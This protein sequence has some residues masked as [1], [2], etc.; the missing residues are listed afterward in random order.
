MNPAIIAVAYN[1]PDSLRRLLTSLDKAVYENDV[2]LVISIDKADNETEVL[3]VAEKFEWKYGK[4][5]IRLFPE[6]QGLRKHIIQ[7]GDLSNEYDAVI[8]L[9]DD[10][11]V[12]KGFYTYMCSALNFYVNEHQITGISLYSHEWNGYAGKFFQPIVD[13]FDTYLG[14]FSITWGQ[15]WTSKWWNN[16]KKWYLEHEDKLGFNRLIPE[17]INHWSCQSWG[18]YFVNYI[19]EKNLYYVIPRTSLSTNFSEVGQHCQNGNTDH[20][21]K[22]LFSNK[23][24]YNF[25]PCE[26]AQ[27]YD[28]F[29]ENM[30]I[31]KYLDKEIADEGIIVDLAGIGRYGEHKRYLLTTSIL[32]YKIV[33]SFGLQMRPIDSNVIYGINGNDI[34]LYDTTKECK[35]KSDNFEN[36]VRYEI[37][38]IPN[39]KLLKYIIEIIKERIFRQVKFK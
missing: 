28:I 29:F 39:R 23:R 8:I 32:Q 20:Q 22:I 10:L 38:G 35:N 26:S 21:V 9:E 1:R 27:I 17:N 33:R 30:L 24:N 6:R 11:V 37:R 4:K 15:C 13:E 36:I 7:C 3:D 34:F 14:Q 31:K 2:T 25:A 12:S 18:R 16:F 5:I 19:V